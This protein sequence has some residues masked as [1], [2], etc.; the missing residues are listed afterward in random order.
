MQGM[1]EELSPV[2][3]PVAEG[4]ALRVITRP[5]S[6][7]AP[8]GAPVLLIH[9]LAS[10]AR[11]WD[12]VGEEL[13]RLG[14]A[15]VAVDQRGHGRSDKPDTGF[16]FAT[17]ASDLL[18]V[19]DATGLERPVVAGQSWGANVVLELAVRHP[20]R[21][22]GVVCVDGAVGSLQDGFPDW[23]SAEAALTPPRLAGTPLADL[24]RRFRAFHPDWPETGIVGGIANFE[25]RDD[26]T[27]APWLTLPRHMAILRQLWEHHP[28]TVYPRLTV[29]VSLLLADGGARTRDRRRAVEA[30]RASGADVRVQWFRPGDHDLHAQFPERVAHAIAELADETTG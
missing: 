25:V 30:I 27:V 3:L 8:P 2:R 20:D 14:H 16:D 15:S 23:P 22:R 29:P 12:G 11:M 24:E 13:A 9:G 6:A 18:A 7:G 21:V 5:A 26:G 19:M 4:I 1:T 28:E 17:L 10:N